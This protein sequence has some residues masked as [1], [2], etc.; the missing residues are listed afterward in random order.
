MF[1]LDNECSNNIKNTIKNYDANFQLVSPTQHCQNAAE[2]AIKTVK[3]HSFSGLVICH[4]E[5]PIT[6]WDRIL[7]RAEMTLNLL[8]N[9]RVNPKLSIRAYLNGSKLIS[10]TIFIL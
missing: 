5:F 2:A 8:R 1:V 10:D 9:R 3:N 7:P 4:K 6:K